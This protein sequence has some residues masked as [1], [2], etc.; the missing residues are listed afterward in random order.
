MTKSG[1]VIIIEDDEDDII[2][3]REALTELD[4]NNEVIF[5]K[6]GQLALEYLKREDVEPFIIICDINMPV[7]DGITL[8]R[9]IQKDAHLRLKCV[10][11][12]FFTTSANR[13]DV[14]E[15]YAN[16]VQGFFIKPHSIHGLRKILKDIIGYWQHSEAPD[17]S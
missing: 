17:Y 16:S 6:N 3:M 8:K 14:L 10:P 11:Y 2:I 4:L 5:F 9:E 15:A 13:Y 7:M 12:L 1:P